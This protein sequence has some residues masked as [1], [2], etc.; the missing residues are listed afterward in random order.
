MALPTNLNLENFIGPC[1]LVIW[2][3]FMWVCKAARFDF[4]YHS[5][6][7]LY[8]LLLAQAYFYFTT[9]RDSI[10]TRLTVALIWSV[11]QLVRPIRN[12]PEFPTHSILET[13]DVIFCVHMIYTYLIVDF[14]NLYKMAQI[15]WWVIASLNW[16]R[17]K[18]VPGV[19]G[20]VPQ[21]NS[22]FVYA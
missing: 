16:H 15:L 10:G 14:A 17:A 22:P 2:L 6:T 1:F 12:S 3:S 18:P 9:Y 11:C 8:G 21:F 19:L 13:L 4:A 7:R 5:S 20:Y